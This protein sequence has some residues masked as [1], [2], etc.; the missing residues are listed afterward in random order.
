MLWQ[1][2][3]L[4]SLCIHN[5]T[6]YDFSNAPVCSMEIGFFKHDEQYSLLLHEVDFGL[7]TESFVKC[8]LAFLNI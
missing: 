5:S 8:V 6:L 7:K 2:P 3:K 1:C 4:R